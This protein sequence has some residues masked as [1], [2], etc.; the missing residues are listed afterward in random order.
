VYSLTNRFLIN[1]ECEIE[2][3][4]TVKPEMRSK[5]IFLLFDY[6]SKGGK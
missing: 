1:G 4:M 2:I 6:F 5:A 3:G